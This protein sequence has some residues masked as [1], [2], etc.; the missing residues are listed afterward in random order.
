MKRTSLLVL[1]TF[2]A[3]G[4]A[5]GSQQVE[6]LDPNDSTLPQDTRRWIAA[7]EDG[8]VAARARRDAAKERLERARARQKR[9]LDEIDFGSKGAK[10]VD[11]MNARF[12]RHQ[13]YLEAQLD[14]AEAL[15]ALAEAK[16]ELATAEQAIIHDIARYDVEEIKQKVEHARRQLQDV[17]NRLR[18]TRES[19]DRTTTRFWQVY[20]QYLKEGGDALRFWTGKGPS[21]SIARSAPKTGTDA[22]PQEQSVNPRSNVNPKDL[23]SNPF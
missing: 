11:S 6:P 12:E 3:F 7:A 17:R 16:Y 5:C 9:M 22:K 13:D 8:V 15:L 18:Q 19:L 1:A 10:V 23:P 4:F 20:A 2:I 21:M 14:R